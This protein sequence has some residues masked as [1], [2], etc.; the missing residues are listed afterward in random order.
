MNDP[1][2]A[3]REPVTPVDPD[4]AFAARLRARLERA[5][6]AAPGPQEEPMT[7]TISRGT[8][9]ALHSVTPYLAVP[10]ATAAV[11]F[12]VDAFG[13]VRRG[14]PIVMP[15][16]RIGHAEVAIG[17]SVLMLAEPFPELGVVAPRDGEA[18]VS[19]RLEVS[20]PD[21][22]V[23]RAVTLGARLERPVGDSPYG[24]GGVVLDP[25]GHRWMVSREPAAGAA[26]QVGDVGY[27]SLWRR[28]VDAADRFYAAVLGWT[29]EGARDGHARRVVGVGQELGMYGGQDAATTMCAYAVDDVDET[30]ALVRAAGGSAEEPLDE[31]WGR[32][33]TC[34]DDQGLPFAV[35][36]AG[37]QNV[38]PDTTRPG[39]LTYLTI[40]VPDAGRARA[41]YGTVLGWRFGPGRVPDGWHVRSASGDETSP[42]TGLHGGHDAAQVV[43]MFVVEDVA[44]AVAAV[45]AAGGT[46][47]D[48]ADAGYGVSARC[49]DDQGAA[50]WLVR[51]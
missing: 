46:A 9:L 23:D 17:D 44:G 26:L 3:L 42:M 13:A 43:P 29:T 34:A 30:V 14:E 18:T 40:E 33:A 5:V 37:R 11:D 27:A 38:R 28:D 39:T 19:M 15:D 4:P 20:D 31:P 10:D 24:R 35:F 41:F 22:V 2:D 1:L 7:S 6:L 16:G 50:F 32:T 12:Y 49:T 8:A 47:D 51:Y 21:A 25:A 48:P 36:A 45:R